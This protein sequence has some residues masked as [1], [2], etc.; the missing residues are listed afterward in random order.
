MKPLNIKGR[1][2]LSFRIT[3]LRRLEVSELEESDM[4]NE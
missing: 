4:L 2:S 3:Y 1:P